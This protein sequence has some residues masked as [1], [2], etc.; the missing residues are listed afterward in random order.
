MVVCAAL[1]LLFVAATVRP[2]F[3][4]GPLGFAVFVLTMSINEIPVLLLG[5]FVISMGLV[6]RPEGMS[7]AV[8]AALLAAA[9]V[10]GLIRLQV[11]A[12][13]ARAA[14]EDGLDEGLGREW[15]RTAQRGDDRSG[16]LP[17]TPWWSGIL[18]PFQRRTKG[19]VRVVDLSYGPDPAHRLDL[20]RGP[21][22]STVRPVLIHLHGGGFV[23]GGRSRESVALLNRLAAHGWLCLSADYRL[24]ADGQHPHP[25]VDTKRLIAWVRASADE[26]GADPS[27]VFLAGCSAGG[28]LALS[29]GLTPDVAELQP[30]FEAADTGVSGVIVW[31][32]Y[33]GPRTDAPSSSPALLARPGAPP[34][35]VVHGTNDTA[36]PVQSAQAVAATIRRASRSPVVFVALPHTQHSFDRF[37]SVRARMA[38]AA[39]EAFLDWVLHRPAED[40]PDT[41]RQRLT[42]EAPSPGWTRW[43]PDSAVACRSSRRP[44]SSPV[45]QAA[46][47]PAV[48]AAPAAGSNA[49]AITSST[50]A[51][52]CTVTVSSTSAGTSS[53][54]GS[55]R[56]GTK[57][58][59]S[60]ARW[61]ASSFCLSP[62]IGRTRPLRV[63]SP[64]IPTSER[65]GRPVASD[66]RAV[67]IVMPAEGPSFGTA[68]AGTCRW[69]ARSRRGRV[70]AQRLG[71]GA[72]EGERDLRGLLHHL[73][74]LTGEGQPGRAVVGGGLDEEHVAAE[75]GD[76]QAGGHTRDRRPL[77]HLGGEARAA[78]EALEVG[79]VDVDAGDLGVGGDLRRRLAQGLGEQPLHLPHA[80]LAGV[81]GRELA[82]RGVGEGDLVGAER[83]CAPAG[84]AA[85]S[86]GRWRPCRPR[87]SRRG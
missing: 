69:I 54:S 63:T 13:T 16:G 40:R 50:S 9:T 43:P 78:D 2:P 3:R 58:S 77:G 81:V 62:P 80:R 32:G 29:A 59:V 56:N 84:G 1:W 45:R 48:S 71:V 12:R 38:A 66:V 23:S 25:L 87:C 14:L 44:R 34:V 36:V 46:V 65:T 70:D 64:V 53:R 83:G 74:E 49:P 68:P 8:L 28:H 4:R 73:A 21:G 86:R 37:G 6:S 42:A 18:L 5:V 61:A 22:A 67:T 20:Y 72:D 60:P 33:L 85:G 82:Q 79:L 26:L 35:L 31:Y 57:T 24:R 7:T 51:T 19:V 17:P 27:R 11:R 15:R 39:A 30:G 76:G 41:P 52:G 75:P 47:A 10:A 55:L